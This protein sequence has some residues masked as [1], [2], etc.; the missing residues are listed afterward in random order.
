MPPRSSQRL[1]RAFP[2]AVAAWKACGCNGLRPHGCGKLKESWPVAEYWA[3]EGIV[4][5][6]RVLP[7]RACHCQVEL[8]PVACG[9]VLPG[10]ACG[11]LP[12]TAPLPLLLIIRLLFALLICPTHKQLQ[13][14]KQEHFKDSSFSRQQ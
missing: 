8:M 7:G 10:R 4:A 1:P 13:L 5:C 9:R 6:G 3:V 11:P 2:G 12:L 14:N